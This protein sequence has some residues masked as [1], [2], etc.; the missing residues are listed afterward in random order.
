MAV[1]SYNISELFKVAFGVTAPIAYQGF[2]VSKSQ[3]ATSKFSDLEI[4]NDYHQAD[5]LSYLG[6]PVIFPMTFKRGQY[7]T[8]DKEGNVISKQ[9]ED[10]S[11][12]EA[13]LADFR[14]AKIIK[15]TSIAGNRG[16]V[17]EMYGWEPWRIT[18][19][20]FCLDNPNISAFEQHK[21]LVEWEDLADSI[22]IIGD[23]FFSKAIYRLSITEI[24]FRQVQGKP[25]VIPF[26]IQAKS[27]NPTELIYF[28]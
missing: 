13:T 12:P 23:L 9:M 22:E 24:D 6:T 5:R 7:K 19:R 16:S 8:Y 18:I 1:S 26:Q 17:T 27:D 10:F 20:G 3:L 15:E 21:K 14:R 2:E 4:I 28:L 25:G 11:L